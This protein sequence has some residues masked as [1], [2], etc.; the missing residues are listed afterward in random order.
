MVSATLTGADTVAQPAIKVTRA[1]AKA[2]RR[3]AVTKVEVNDM[4]TPVERP[5]AYVF[6]VTEP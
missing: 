4:A 6:L 3:V 5:R 1:A 2:V